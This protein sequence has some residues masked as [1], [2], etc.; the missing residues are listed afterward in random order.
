MKFYYNFQYDLRTSQK[1]T[2]LTQYASELSIELK[3]IVTKQNQIYPTDNRF[4]SAIYDENSDLIYSTIKNPKQNLDQIVYSSDEIIQYV[5]NPQSSYLKATYILIKI[6]NDKKWEKMIMYKIIIFGIFAFIGIFIFGY[7]LSK[8]FLKPMRDAFHLLNRFI[9][10][11]THEL[12]TPVN[13]IIAN[14]EMI[15]KVNI[16]DKK[17]VQKINRIDIG[18]KTIS[19]IYEDLTYL[20]LNNKIISQ[21]ENVNVNKI[22]KQRIEYFD[23]QLTIKKINIKTKLEKKVMLNIDKKKISK[24]IDNLLSNA[25]KYN[26]FKGL[27][28]IILTKNYF[29]IKDTG[30]GI[31]DENIDLIFNR[32]SRFSENVGGFG[33]GLNIVKL[34]CSEYNLSIEIQ[35]KLDIGTEIKILFNQ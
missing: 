19:N 5:K 22:F 1:R 4:Q 35:S 30:C 21:N 11:T 2:L 25:I 33:I 7:F 3:N 12:N 6:H 34:I 8:L 28:T 32:Y 27:I 9:K 13:T 18:A 20:I 17:L 29:S 31:S 15:D 24:L 16:D 26:K 23:T 14:I 10:D